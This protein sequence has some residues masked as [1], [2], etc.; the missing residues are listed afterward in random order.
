MCR[1]AGIIDKH[2]DLT[3]SSAKVKEMCAIMA[4]GGPDGEGFYEN[5][6]DNVVFGHR[7]LALIDLSITGHQPMIHDD[8]YVISFNGEI[9]N[10]LILKKKLQ[11]LGFQFRTKSDTEVILIGFAYWGTA[12]FDKLSGMFAF[13]LYD[14]TTNSTYLVRDQSGIKPLY[15]SAIDQRLIF[16]SEVK[17]FKKLL[18]EENP[19]WKIYFLAFG[20]IPEP[21]TTLKDVLMLPKAQYLKWDHQTGTHELHCFH[22][23]SHDILIH[24]VEA[25]QE[26]VK[27][28]IED[29]VARHLIADEPIGVFLSGGIDSGLLTLLADEVQNKNGQQ[30]H[31]ISINFKDE[32]FSEKAYQ[33]CILKEVNSKH[34]EYTLDESTFAEHFPSALAAMDQ[35]TA[36]GINSWFINYYAKLNGL[37]AFLSGIGADELF[38]GYPSF[39]RM[40]IVSFLS[41]LPHFMLK[42]ALKIN[43]VT[44]KRTYYL[45]YKN[46]I[47]KYLF[48]R[49]FFTPDEISKLLDIPVSK[50]DGVLKNLSIANMPNALGNGEQAS[51]LET[52]LYM[53]NQLLKDTD[54]MSMQHGIE[55]RVP[56]LDKELLGLINSIAEPVKYKNTKKKGLLID[57]FINLL[58]RKIW[59][60]PKMGF[61]FPFQHWLK[62]DQYFQ[63][64]LAKCNNQRAKELIANFK[65][66]D[67]HWSKAMA[68]YQVF[69][70]IDD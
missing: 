12:V 55:I 70:T 14:K 3:L 54:F 18:K 1:I 32:Q 13:A 4:H 9:Y 20:H 17:A 51:W 50:I 40:G 28:T 47:G 56:F 26:K 34:Y 52:N 61:T 23:E 43:S 66:G 67:L 16:A 15:Y 68:I 33:D 35:P 19:N 38:G 25:A 41:S 37:K 22:K 53:Q 60:R 63:Q 24:K 21:Y 7:R 11:D 6:N 30:L 57:S 46:T 69:N 29:A 8:K 48:L 39:D 42:M 27:N 65:K 5:A 2:Q 45:H 36:D 62:D 44:L 31:T 59:D 64:Q 58:P 10:Y 49:G